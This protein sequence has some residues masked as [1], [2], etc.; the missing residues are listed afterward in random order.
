[1]IDEVRK[2]VPFPAIHC[3]LSWEAPM[4]V[5]HVDS[6]ETF[7][8]DLRPKIWSDRDKGFFPWVQPVSEE[9][10]QPCLAT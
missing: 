8:C 3:L 6:A 9:E 2:G 1:M 7:C 10:S 4:G 5:L